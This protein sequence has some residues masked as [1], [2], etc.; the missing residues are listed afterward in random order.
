MMRALLH[1]RAS[2]GFRALLEK[3]KPDAL[4]LDIV[5]EADDAGFAAAMRRA[6]VLLHVLRP[7]T[8]GD[9][10][11]A[12]NLKLIQKIGVGVNTIDLEAAKARGIAVCNMPGTNSQA[13]AE[14]TLM[15]MLAALRRVAVFDPQ[16]RAGDGWRPDALELDQ[17]GEICGRTIGFVGY[18]A[19]PQRLA[20]ALRA[21]GADIMYTARSQKA[22]AP[23]RFVALE[24]L[25]AEADIISLHIPSTPETR[26]LIGADAIARMKQGAILINTA[27]GDLVDEA[28]LV[29]ALKSGHL[30]AA[31]LDVFAQ[32]PAPADCPLFALSNV[33]LM[34]H[35]AWLTPQTLKRSLS[36][37]FEN[38]RR[39]A[40]GE[41]LLHQV[42]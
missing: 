15:L 20:P 19:V 40:S 30:S 5:D 4:A 33:V 41:A 31:G 14:M 37:A 13:V 2:P 29:A 38:C 39:I 9:I 34:P 10:A 24:T 11:G 22:D 28:A 3:E 12:P 17:V 8:A 27:R 18:G 36:V 42:I 23:G 1:Y 7:V 21:L 6:D 25:V 32:E 35:L 16:T 26:G